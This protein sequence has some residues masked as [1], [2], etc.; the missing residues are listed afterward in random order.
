MVANEHYRQFSGD[1]IL[2]LHFSDF[3]KITEATTNQIRHDCL[4]VRPVAW[5]NS[6]PTGRIFMKFNIYV[7]FENR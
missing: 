7:F 6:T 2:L 4:S 1:F 5:N 3:R